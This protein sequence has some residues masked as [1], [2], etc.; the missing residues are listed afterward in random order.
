MTEIL[1]NPLPKTLPNFG[2]SK[3]YKDRQVWKDK[4]GKKYKL[5][6]ITDQHLL[7]IIPF[8]EK[9]AGRF[10]HFYPNLNGTFA[11][12]FA[13]ADFFAELDKLH[14]AIGFF[15]EVAKERELMRN[16]KVVKKSNLWGRLL[17]SRFND[18]EVLDP[19]MLQE[20]EF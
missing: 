6:D 3:K 11:Q 15:K 16:G 17:D 2:Y 1:L 18:R 14:N 9:K 20:D 19:I 4:E 10:F 7:N 8:L 5:R 12:E 13:E